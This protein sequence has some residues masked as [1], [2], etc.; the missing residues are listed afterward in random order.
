MPRVLLLATRDTWWTTQAEALLEAA[1]IDGSWT[2]THGVLELSVAD[3]TAERVAELLAEQLGEELR[4][5][6]LRRPDTTPRPP[7]FFQPAFAAAVCCAVALL[8]VH[9][10]IGPSDERFAGAVM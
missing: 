4:R 5:R 8:V 7:L 6:T 2:V 3:S 10:I 9:A 1:G